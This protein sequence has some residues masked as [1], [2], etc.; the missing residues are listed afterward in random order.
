MYFF[1]HILLL[2]L[3][4]SL[5]SCTFH[6]FCKEEKWACFSTLSYDEKYQSWLLSFSILASLRIVSV[7]YLQFLY[8]LKISHTKRQIRKIFLTEKKYS[9]EV[10]ATHYKIVQENIW[11][12][13]RGDFLCTHNFVNC[14]T[15]FFE[16]VV[17]SLVAF[18]VSLTN[19]CYM[20]L[21]LP[22]VV[23]ISGSTILM[24]ISYRENE[25]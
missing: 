22:L 5:H 4:S 9:Y 25:D 1:R 17:G 2:L 18:F 12:E 20:F 15:L 23:V 7:T 3:L 6:A 24:N 16:L 21:S 8:L 14:L 19:G 11:E 13:E 10:K